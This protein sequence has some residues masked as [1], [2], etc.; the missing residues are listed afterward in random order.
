MLA[1]ALDRADIRVLDSPLNHKHGRAAQLSSWGLQLDD[2]VQAPRAPLLL[3]VDDTATPMKYRLAQYHRLCAV[4]GA[5]PAAEVLT[6]DHG[7]KRYLVY[8]LASPTRQPG[9]N[10]PALAWIDTPARKASVPTRFAIT[11][12]AFKDGQG[13][14]KVEVTLDGKRVATAAYGTSMPNVAQY[15]RISTDPQQPRVGFRAEVDA[16]AYSPGMH[17]L[18][19]RL[20]GTDGSVEPWAEQPIR[21][22]PR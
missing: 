9:C 16:S 4:F 6:V 3:I 7:R 21:I 22:Q 15:W 14:A 5:L 19:L 18:G 2:L 20:Y 11:G 12:W 1:F 17:W 13:L 8:R 10:T